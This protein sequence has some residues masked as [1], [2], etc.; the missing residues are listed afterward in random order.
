[1]RKRILNAGLQSWSWLAFGYVLALQGQ[2]T[3]VWTAFNDHFAGPA[4]GSYTTAWNVFGTLERAPGNSGPL[5]DAA[6]G[7]SLPV[8]LTITSLRKRRSGNNF[9]R[10]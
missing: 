3:L 10:A 1:M 5:T 9:R 7:T 4:S 8:T 2:P 6:T